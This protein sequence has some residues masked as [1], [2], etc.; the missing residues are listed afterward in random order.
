M[1][2]DLGGTEAEIKIKIIFNKIKYQNYYLHS[3]Y[4][5]FQLLLIYFNQPYLKY[6]TVSILP[7]ESAAGGPYKTSQMA[8]LTFKLPEFSTA[9][10]ITW[11]VDIV[12]SLVFECVHDCIPKIL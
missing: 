9:K 8:T 12:E 7:L 6:S 5:I 10:D 11:Q 4:Y 1:P 2:Y 3:N